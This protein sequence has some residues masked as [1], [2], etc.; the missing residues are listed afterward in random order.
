MKKPQPKQFK[1]LKTEHISPNFQRITLGCDD[2]TSYP[3]DCEGG[4][5]KLLFN[6]K[7]ETDLSTLNEGERPIMRTYTIRQYNQEKSSIEVDFVRHTTSSLQCGFAARW[8]SNVQV[9]ESIHIG[10]P[11]LIKDMQTNVDWFFMI[12]DMTALPALS[13]KIKKLPPS[14]MG[15]A[16]IKVTD[17]ADIQILDMPKGI[18]VHWLTNNET[19]PATVTSLNWLKGDVSVWVAC[20]FEDMKVL[21]HY[22]RNEKQVDKDNLYISSY[23]KEGTT[24]DGHKII[25]QKDAIAMES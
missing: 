24:E 7:G 18:Q 15:Y 13:A 4:Y 11:G 20:E 21:R 22:F 19:L 17:E 9:G 23:W 16:V 6:D 14:A 10:G 5:I 8:A 12:A 3:K 25:K 1:V 2:L